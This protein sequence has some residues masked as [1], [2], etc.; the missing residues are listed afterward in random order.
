MRSRSIRFKMTCWLTLMLAVMVCA[1]FLIIY[2][3]SRVI[4][5]RTVRSYLRSTVVE[6]TDKITFSTTAGNNGESLYVPYQDGYLEIDLD[7]LDV[8][9]FVHSGLYNS[10]GEMLYGENPLYRYQTPE[11]TAEKLW[12]M[13]IGGQ[14]YELYDLPL[15]L[16]PDLPPLW[17]RGIVPETQGAVLLRQTLQSALLLLPFLLALCLLSGYL[18]SGRLLSPIRK[19]ESTAARISKG[20]DLKQ[21]IDIG[22]SSDEIGRL[23]AVFNSMLTRLEHAFEAERQFTSD[24][25][26]ELRTPTSVILAQVDYSLERQ[27]S[28]EEY[29][30][31]LRVI[32]RQGRRM[33]ALIAD[34]LDLSRI[35]QGGK[36]F[37]MEAVD[38]SQVVHEVSESCMQG[39]DTG[40]RLVE[41]IQPG[42]IM[43]GNRLLLCRLAQNLISN[44]Y[45]Y[46][47]PD[48]RI[49][50]SLKQTMDGIIMRVRDDGIGIPIQE[51]EKIFQR[52]YRCDASRTISG[53]GLGLPMVKKIAEM[54]GGRVTVDSESGKGSVFSVIF[55]KNKYPL[56]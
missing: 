56:S 3:T 40:I 51:Q 18:L 46:G 28:P 32:R 45:K 4:L 17:I 15:T 21:R 13:R 41:D 20:N 6:N 55:S 43:Q 30:D 31:A 36:F 25:S 1:A 7:F 34:M 48:G 47:K 22:K 24:V 37:P 12:Q 8:V 23:A 33:E 53:T 19:I 14:W 44:A 54:H 50:V 5:N 42:I 9:S 52:F 16:S 29:R 2:L 39:Q 10:K 38:F 35:D 26:H 49:D 11:F 27:R